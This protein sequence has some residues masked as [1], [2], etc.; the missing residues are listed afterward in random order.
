ML[1]FWLIYS[2]KSFLKIK[3][4]QI[5][6]VVNWFISLDLNLKQKKKYLFNY[7]IINILKS[8]LVIK[9]KKFLVHDSLIESMVE[10]VMS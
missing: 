1:L 4:S 2:I 9:L 6:I 8:K 5:S 10:L 7:I 3:N